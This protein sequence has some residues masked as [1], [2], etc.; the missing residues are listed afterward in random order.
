M[1]DAHRPIGVVV[2]AT[3]FPGLAV[4]DHGMPAG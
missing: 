2:A 4:V 3:G 1:L